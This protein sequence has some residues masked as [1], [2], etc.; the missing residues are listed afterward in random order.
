LS[1]IIKKPDGSEG[2][3]LLYAHKFHFTN[4]GVVS[5]TLGGLTERLNAGALS[6]IM[7]ETISLVYH[8]IEGRGY[9]VIKGKKFD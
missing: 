5:K 2:I 4:S 8:V 9:S 7:R 6:P 3:L 1:N